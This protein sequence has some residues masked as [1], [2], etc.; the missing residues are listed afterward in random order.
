MA[1]TTPTKARRRLGII[2]KINT[3]A[4]PLRIRQVNL[5]RSKAALDLLLREAREHKTD[6]LSIQ[7]PNLR[8]IAACRNAYCDGKLDSAIIVCNPEEIVLKKVGRG[9]G[10]VFLEL[11][12]YVI[13]SCYFSPNKNATEFSTFLDNINGEVSANAGKPV[14]IC[15]DFNAKS[16]L[17]GSGI[18]D[19]RG[20]LLEE[21][22]AACDLMTANV[23]SAPTFIRRNSTSIIDV[24]LATDSVLERIENWRVLEDETLS[25]H[26]YIEFCLKSIKPQDWEIKAAKGWKLTE[27]GVGAIKAYLVGR[28][29]IPKKNATETLTEACDKFLKKKRKSGKPPVYWWNE[30]IKEKRKACVSARRSLARTRRRHPEE[31]EE[32][33]N[34]YKECR[35]GT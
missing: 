12:E 4:N 2:N 22:M 28:R 5:N 1:P 17:W 8:R 32:E 16:H 33:E 23:G 27:D 6:I 29:D 11:R 34:H 18:Q 19:K 21:M 7:E 3:K 31:A 35:G 24:T 13:F 14:I 26:R 25:D 30:D 15:G 9:D 10:Y 20:E